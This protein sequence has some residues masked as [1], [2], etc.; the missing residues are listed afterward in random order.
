MNLIRNN[1]VT[2]KAVQWATKIYGQ[3]IGQLKAQKTRRRPNPVVD[4]SIDIPYELLEVKKGITIAMDVLT[5][6][7]L[8]FLSKIS[9]YLYFRTMQY[10][11]NT[12]SGYYQ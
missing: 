1:P 10:M 7:G 6:N 3:D 4:T 9:L 8:K 11:P 5:I 2:K 12:T